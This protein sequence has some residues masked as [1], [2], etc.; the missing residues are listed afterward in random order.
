MTENS[1]SETLLHE[2]IGWFTSLIERGQTLPKVLSG[3]TPQR[4]QFFVYPSDF[5]IEQS[6]HLDFMRTILRHERAV[7]FAVGYR[8]MAYNEESQTEQERRNFFSGQV[9]QYFGVELAPKDGSDWSSGV[10]QLHTSESTEPPW[11]LA[12]LL[13]APKDEELEKKYA[14]IWTKFRAQ[15]HWVQR[16]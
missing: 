3:I 6:E 5:P 13:S 8:F 12:D 2:F 7:A 9:G 11:F 15:V 10:V 1:L 4:E 14:Q 16:A